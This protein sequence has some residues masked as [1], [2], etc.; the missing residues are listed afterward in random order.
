MTVVHKNLAAGRWFTLSLMEQLGNIGSE[1]ERTIRWKNQHNDVRANTAMERA[2]EL[3]DLT[4]ADQRWI[5]AHRLKELVRLREVLCDWFYGK[6][7]Y[8]S[9][10]DAWKKYFLAFGIAARL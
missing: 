7:E 4:I 3:L 9:S 1:I 8:Q 6:N 2:L 5:T 10:D